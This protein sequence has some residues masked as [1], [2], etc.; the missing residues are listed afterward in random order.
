MSKNSLQALE[1]KLAYVFQSASLLPLALSHRSVGSHNNER[2]EFL[3]DSLL[4]LLIAEALFDKFPK[5]KEGELSRLR[6]HL[7]K[8]VTLAEVARE[9]ELGQYILLGGG[10][11]K[12]GG[13]RR[14]SILAD[15]VEA[16][17]GAVYRD[18]DMDTC[19]SLVLKLFASRLEN[20]SLAV[21]ARDAKTQLQEYMQERN[22]PLP[23]YHV[24]REYGEAHAR[25]YEIECRVNGIHT[26]FSAS[27]SSKRS[28]EKLAAAIALEYIAEQ[29]S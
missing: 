22:K 16:I 2:L 8:G 14:A 7:V 18:S 9:L 24:L 28:A 25:M 5:A 13:H 6:A 1:K 4:N 29:Q 26:Y 3:G 15:V 20:L 11:L 12:S 27:A 19:K 23:E 10:E 21:G 17:I